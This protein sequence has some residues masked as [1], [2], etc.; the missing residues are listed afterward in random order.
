MKTIVVSGGFDPLHP[1]HLRM[2]QDASEYGRVVVVLNSDAWLI[3]KKGYCFFE[4]GWRAEIL[5]GLST[6]TMVAPVDD[7]DGT[8]CEALR[9]LR[10]DYF[11]NGGD[12]GPTNTPELE[13]CRDLGITPIFELG[14]GKVASSSEA[15]D[16]VLRAMI[17]QSDRRLPRPRPALGETDDRH[18]PSGG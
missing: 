5:C 17:C 11:G 4:Y 18:N 1:G 10:P 12:R 9:R 13:V 6:V 16:R 8:V 15:V 7:A 14:G 3:R 2:I